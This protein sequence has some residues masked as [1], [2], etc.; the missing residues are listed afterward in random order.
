MS[1][2]GKRGGERVPKTDCLVR[3]QG[4]WEDIESGLYYNGF[5]YY[6]PETGRYISP[7]PLGLEAGLNFY[8]YV[9]SPV[10]WIDPFGLACTKKQEAELKRDAKAIH[11]KF[12][13]GDEQN[14][15]TT[16]VAILTDPKTGKQTKVFAVSSDRV[17][18]KVVKEAE[19][20]GYTLVR[21]KEGGS[22]HAEQIIMDH[23]AANGLQSTIAPNRPACG[24]ER[25][26]CRGRADRSRNHTVLDPD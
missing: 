15:R 19:R 24:P 26:D 3:F 21:M 12:K 2:G 18:A 7:D 16:A 25:Q 5:R 4:Q 11:A 14:R 8:A 10:N 23:A 6:D 17:S 1:W 22:T 9:P 20:R 13:K